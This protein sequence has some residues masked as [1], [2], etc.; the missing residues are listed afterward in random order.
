MQPDMMYMYALNPSYTDNPASSPP[1][2]PRTSLPADL[3][4]AGNQ[5]LIARSGYTTSDTTFAAYCP[6]TG[7]DHEHS[8]CGRFD[9]VYKNDY[10]V[11]GRTEFNDYNEAMTSCDNQPIACIVNNSSQTDC[12]VAGGCF[13]G[14][15][16]TRGG[17]AWHAYQGGAPVSLLHTISPTYVS[18]TADMTSFYN[19]ASF[20]WPQISTNVTHASRSLVYNRSANMVFYYDRGIT[21]NAQTKRTFQVVT[22]ASPTY[23][24]NTVT[25]NSHYSIGKARFTSVLPAGASIVDN[26][27]E[28]PAV[29]DDFI[30]QDTFYVDGGSATSKQFLSCLE[31]GDF[32]SFTPGTCTS[33]SSS[34]GTNYDGAVLGTNLAM[35]KRTYSDTVSTVTFPASS[36]TWIAVADLL[37]STTYSLSCSGCSASVTTDT[38]GTA[39]FSAGGS[40]NVVITNSA[41]VVNPAPA[42]F[43]AFNWSG[44][45][46]RGGR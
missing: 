30:P 20:Q 18:Y 17:Q 43:F 13:E 28:A 40:G 27:L 5:N 14:K 26:G 23:S 37:P 2:D 39:V 3:Y 38:A 31:W 33:V 22:Q 29:G 46:F 34:A 36:A 21:A 19:W 11:K 1:S 15:T 32:S 35:F 4:S 25:W 7:I 42:P 10:L 6:W 8:F 24:G 16:A 41:P 12:T 9:L 45:L 44:W